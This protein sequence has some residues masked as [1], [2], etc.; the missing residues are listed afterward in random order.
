MHRNHSPF[1]PS[2]TRLVFGPRFANRSRL[3]WLTLTLASRASWASRAMGLATAAPPATAAALPPPSMQRTDIAGPVGSG[4]FGSSIITLPNGNFIVGDAGY[5]EGGL[6]DIG[7]VYLYNGATLALISTLKGSS[8]ND[9]VGT[10]S[11][12]TVLTGGQHFVVSS[13]GWNMPGGAA[14]VGAVTLCSVT[15][16]CN[17]TVSAAHSLIGATA[18]DQVGLSG[19]TALANGNYVV[20]RSGWDNSGVADANA[21]TWCQ[22]ASNSCAGQTVS[23][24]NS[25]VGTAASDC[26]GSSGIT[27][28]PNGNF[29]ST[30]TGWGGCSLTRTYNMLITGTCAT[31]T[32]NPASLAAGTLGAADSQP[33]SASGG[34]APY[35]F[36]VSGGALPAGLSLDASTG[37]LSGTPA[38]TGLFSFRVTAT[39]L[40]GCNGSRQYVLTINCAPLSFNPASLPN[41]L[42]GTAYSQQLSVSPAGNF[43]CWAVCRPVF[44]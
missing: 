34:N 2:F 40:G 31:I 22:A 13:S 35:R 16:G 18:N 3:P 41:G 6:T 23:A 44:R 32:V 42:R 7:A 8:T 37:V 30:T 12:I 10:S 21:L 19:I 11:A 20:R 33:L 43:C 27:A 14:D 5:D 24:A 38:A 29:S 25:L 15:T 26:I 9:R 4:S 39:G 28:P 17:G 36:T 1:R